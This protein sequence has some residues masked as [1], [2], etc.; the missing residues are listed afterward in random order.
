MTLHVHLLDEPSS[1]ALTIFEG[2]LS[3][4]VTLTMGPPQPGSAEYEILVAGRPKREYL[5]A[6]PNLRAVVIPFAGVPHPTREL[7][8]DFPRIAVHNLHYN[9]AM[10]AEMAI[11][12]MLAVSKH[13]LPCDKALRQGDWRPRYGPNPSI[14]LDGKTVVVLGLGEIGRRVGRVCA[15]FGMEVLAIRRQPQ[16][17]HAED[18]PVKVFGL[19][20]LATLLPRAHA[21]VIALP[22][23][24]ATEGL[25]G[26][27]ELGSMPAGSLLVNVGRGSI[28]DQAALYHALK[29]GHLGGAGLDVWYNYPADEISRAATQ[30]SDYPFHELDNVVMSPH[31]A[32]GANDSEARRMKCLAE[33]LNIA[34]DGNELPNR[35]DLGE[36]Y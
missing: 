27:Q 35:V 30:P 15:G 23:T 4:S 13:L 7:L 29:A 33:M 28:V 3:D 19:D 34:A 20:A 2:Q 14:T 22:A 6:S 24:P 9:A 1:S 16:R 10:T 12:L 18:Y 11:A 31:R 26:A 17:G 21:L 25:I 36:G 8:A 5:T 32:G